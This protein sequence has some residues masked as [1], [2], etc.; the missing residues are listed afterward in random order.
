MIGISLKGWDKLAPNQDAL[1]SGVLT[2][3]GGCIIV[4]A[5][6]GEYLFEWKDPGICAVAN[7]EDIIKKLKQPS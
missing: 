5:Y 7:F 3:L 2:Q 4:D 1:E 6:T